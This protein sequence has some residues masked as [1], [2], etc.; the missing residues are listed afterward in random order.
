MITDGRVAGLGALCAVAVLALAPAAGAR[1]QASL[2]VG[3]L[4]LTDV[5]GSADSATLSTGKLGGLFVSIE[6]KANGLDPVCPLVSPKFHGFQ[7]APVPLVRIDAGAGDDRID[8][9]RVTTPLQVTLGPGSDA[10]LG[11]SANDT[12]AT[13]ADGQRDVV[14]CGAGQDAV[15]G[16]ADPNDEIAASCETAQRSFMPAKLPK[17]LT[18]APNGTVTVPIGNAAV[19]LA[20]AAT[21]A[22]AP[23]NG[24]GKGK[25]IAKSSAPQASGPVKLRFKL[26]K[27][28]SGSLS[29]RPSVRVQVGVVAIAA[30]GRRFPLSLHSGSPGPLGA[31]A[32][33]D[34]QLRL[35]IPAR[36]RHPHGH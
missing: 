12:L 20:F 34:N 4:T 14:E 1:L 17:T 15:E 29:H 18:V 19:P 28:S 24:A 13:L 11:G 36:L 5:S 7:C 2:D 32:L 26:P 23:P 9:A 35:K 22:T 6:D 10:F 8:A 25:T 30:D 33:H 3:G 16:M 21:L 31:I 27:L